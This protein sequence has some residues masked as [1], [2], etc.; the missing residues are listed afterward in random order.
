MIVVPACF[1]LILILLWNAAGSARDALLVFSAV[2]LALTGGVFALW[3]SGMPFS[4]SAA[5]GFI[6][7]SGIAVLN[8]LGAA[9]RDPTACGRRGDRSRDAIHDGALMRLRPVADDGAGRL[10]WA[11]CRWRSRPAP[12]RKCSGRSRPW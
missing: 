2:P 3:L 1:L 7:L 12:A 8:G 4:V 11:L 5:V 10:A 6:A 9:E